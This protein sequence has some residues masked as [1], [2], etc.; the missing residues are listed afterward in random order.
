MPQELISIFKR[1]Q[2]DFEQI[3]LSDEFLLIKTLEK[4]SYH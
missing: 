1:L 4:L 2:S 3:K